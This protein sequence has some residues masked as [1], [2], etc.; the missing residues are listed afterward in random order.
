MPSAHNT[1][2]G[3]SKT[4]KPPLWPDSWT[5][6]YPH[7]VEGTSLPPLREPASKGNCYLFSLPPG[8]AG[9]PVKPCLNFLSGLWSISVDWGR[10]RTLACNTSYFHISSLSIPG[11]TAC[12]PVILVSALFHEHF[13]T[14]LLCLECFPPFPHQSS[15]HLS[16]SLRCHLWHENTA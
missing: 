6:P 1:T 9:A 12:S 13:Y 8:A 11:Y 5:H 14:F 3:V 4:P 7:R 2:W 15:A 10:P 16:F